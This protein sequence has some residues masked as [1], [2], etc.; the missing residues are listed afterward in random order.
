[1][2][3]RTLSI[4]AVAVESIHSSLDRRLGYA[5]GCRALDLTGNLG[6]KPNPTDTFWRP[7]A[8]TSDRDIL[9]PM[10]CPEC[11]RLKGLREKAT[12]ASVDAET[13]VRIA[14]GRQDALE[15]QRLKMSAEEAKSR[16]AELDREFLDHQDTHS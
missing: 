11:G 1:M 6:A 10:D 8:A 3:W 5:W 9:T 4:S 14:S 12:I 15:F 7:E 16:L 13:E 2:R